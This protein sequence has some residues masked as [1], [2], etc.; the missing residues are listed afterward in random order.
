MT[1]SSRSPGDPPDSTCFKYLQASYPEAGLI[2]GTY[3]V[4]ARLLVVQ[5]QNSFAHAHAQYGACTA[6]RPLEQSMACHKDATSH[7]FML[8]AL[9]MLLLY[10]PKMVVSQV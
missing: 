4:S 5:V 7:Q 8:C 3:G 2:A 9:R 10:S 1:R 6:K